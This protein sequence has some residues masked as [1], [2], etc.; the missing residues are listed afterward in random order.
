MVPGRAD[1]FFIN[2]AGVI[3]A[4]ENNPSGEFGSGRDVLKVDVLPKYVR[5]ADLNAVCNP[6]V[7]LRDMTLISNFPLRAGR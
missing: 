2:N 5:F 1:A 7:T 4:W 6:A 3:R